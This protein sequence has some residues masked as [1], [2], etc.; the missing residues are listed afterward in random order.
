M[1]NAFI[2]IS[3]ITRAISGKTILSI[4]KIN[5]KDSAD[6]IALNIN[7]RVPGRKFLINISSPNFNN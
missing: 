3:E 7:L 6:E 5:K 4:S 2:I 1:L